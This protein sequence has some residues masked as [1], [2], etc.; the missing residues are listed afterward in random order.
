MKNEKFYDVSCISY[1]DY[2]FEQCN[3]KEI[4]SK[5]KESSKADVK[6]SQR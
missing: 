3:K 2:D 6:C 5:I 4:L 1:A